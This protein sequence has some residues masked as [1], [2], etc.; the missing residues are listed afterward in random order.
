MNRWCGV[1]YILGRLDGTEIGTEDIASGIFLS[2]D[3]LAQ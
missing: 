3:D 2:C 1:L